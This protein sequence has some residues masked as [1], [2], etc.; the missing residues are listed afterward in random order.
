MGKP[1]KFLFKKLSPA[2]FACMFKKEAMQTKAFLLSFAPNSEYVDKVIAIYKDNQFA[3]LVTDYLGRAEKE[4]VNTMFIRRIEKHVKDIIEP[5]ASCHRLP[6]RL[7][8]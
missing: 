8:C 6:G 3:G 1:F 4:T 5:S 2:E 7:F